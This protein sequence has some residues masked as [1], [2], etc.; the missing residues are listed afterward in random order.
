M[1]P[2]HLVKE[3]FAAKAVQRYIQNSLLYQQGDI[4]IEDIEKAL[5]AGRKYLWLAI[6]K[7]TAS[8]AGAAITSIFD[9]PRKRSA[10]VE[11]LGGESFPEWVG[12]L[13]HQIDKWARE[14]QAASIDIIGRK[15]W[16]RYLKKYNFTHAYTI[17]TRRL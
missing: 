4:A 8:P 3:S 15:G 2:L 1:V 12:L 7:K 16:E 13:D 14:N 11:Y 5:C 9:S 17:V 10:C 6:S